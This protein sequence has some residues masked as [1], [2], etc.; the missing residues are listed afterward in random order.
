MSV[1]CRSANRPP[2]ISKH[3]GSGCPNGRSSTVERPSA[4][5]GPARPI[6]DPCRGHPGGQRG[7]LP[8]AS[9]DDAG[10]GRRVR[11]GQVGAE[12]EHSAHPAAQRRNHAGADPVRRSARCRGADRLGATAGRRAANAGDP[13]RPHLYHLS[14]TDEFAVAAAYDRRPGQRGAAAASPRHVSRSQGAD[15]RDAAPGRLSRRSAGLAQLSVRA[16][17]R[18]AAAR[19]DRDGAGLPAGPADR[20]RA[21]DRSRRDDPGA[22]PEADRRVAERTRHGACC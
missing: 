20:R 10:R 12:P 5:R 21:D 8:H 4:G 17:G 6:R 19:D 15:S 11:F 1:N 22:D 18:S 9:G 13:R 3:W 16:F 2:P 14:G 7:Q